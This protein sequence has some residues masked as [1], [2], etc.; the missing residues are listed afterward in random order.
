M[1][2]SSTLPPPLSGSYWVIPGQF[3][4]G[5]HPAAYGESAI[6]RRVQELL[7]SGISVFYDLT[8]PRI[9]DRHYESILYQQAAEFDLGVRYFNFPIEDFTAPSVETVRTILDSID[10]NIEEGRSIYVH[11]FAGIG[12]TGTIV[13]CYLARHGTTGQAV[14]HQ[15]A[16]LRSQLPSWYRQSPEAPDQIDLVK[17]WKEGA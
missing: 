12:R 3:L 13:G 7:R 2:P 1:K 6:P 9:S 5:E 4:A 16:Q 14:L 17:S 8:E 15:I 11:C 10:Q